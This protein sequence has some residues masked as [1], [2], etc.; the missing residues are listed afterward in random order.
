M[1]NDRLHARASK[2]FDYVISLSL[3]HI[4]EVRPLVFVLLID[5]PGEVKL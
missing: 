5:V 4:C 3:R 2:L 1:E